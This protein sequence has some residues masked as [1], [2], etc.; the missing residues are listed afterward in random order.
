[1]ATLRQNLALA[2]QPH[3]EV[4]HF[5]THRMKLSKGCLRFGVLSAGH[6]FPLSPEKHPARRVEPR[7]LSHEVWVVL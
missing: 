5:I 4:S 2:A 3:E 1:M 6:E 7:Q